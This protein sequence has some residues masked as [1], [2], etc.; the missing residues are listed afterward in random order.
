MNTQR[1]HC[2][3]SVQIASFFWSVFSSNWTDHGDLLRK[4][5]YSVQTQENT[6]QKKIRIWTLFTQW[7]ALTRENDHEIIY[8][9]YCLVSMKNDIVTRTF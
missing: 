4:S 2:V 9:Y 8:S 5:P 6:D 3:K 7:E 1:R